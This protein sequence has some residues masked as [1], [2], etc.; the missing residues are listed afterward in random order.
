MSNPPQARLTLY[1]YPPSSYCQ[2][3][4]MMLAECGLEAR[5][6]EVDPFAGT[7]AIPHPFNAVP[8]LEEG[9]FRLYETAAI[10][11][12]LDAAHA[13]GRFT[14]SH[15]RALARMVQV[16]GIADS[17]AYWPL[18]RQVYGERI[19][20]P[21][22]G[23]RPNEALI[24]EGLE[25]APRVL[26]ALEDIAAEGL[27][28]SGKALTLADI[29]LAPMLGFFAATPDGAKMLAGYPALRGWFGTIAQRQSYRG[30]SPL[31]V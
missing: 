31:A 30:T 20:A 15:P 19:F 5:I 9:D 3:V 22:E 11:R 6:I 2:S 24:A 27:I 13:G 26:A 16:E 10:L 14:P 25:R 28:L 12:Y 21:L 29:H 7:D 8:V 23:E 17:Q 18:V 1:A 4:R